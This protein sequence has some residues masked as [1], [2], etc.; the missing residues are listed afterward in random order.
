[1]TKVRAVS[2]RTS[3]ASGKPCPDREPSPVRSGWI[4][5]GAYEL[6]KRVDRAKR[7]EPGTVRGPAGLRRGPLQV[8][9]CPS[10]FICGFASARFRLIPT[11]D[12]LRPELSCLSARAHGRDFYESRLKPLVSA[13]APD[14]HNTPCP[15]R[16][17]MDPSVVVLIWIFASAQ[18]HRL[19]PCPPPA[20]AVALSSRPGRL[21]RL[22]RKGCHEL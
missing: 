12:T 14:A 21:A 8:H 22:Q 4:A 5:T 2:T 7:C 20:F 1:M 11:Q 17:S 16:N 13:A 15:R 10:V 19:V 6:S 9:L 18:S 3:V